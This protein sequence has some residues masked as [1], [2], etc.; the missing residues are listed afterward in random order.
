MGSGY[1]PTIINYYEEF[2]YNEELQEQTSPKTNPT[3]KHCKNNTALGPKKRYCHQSFTKS[4]YLPIY[5]N[6]SNTLL[7]FSY[8]GAQLIF[9]A[10]I[11]KAGVVRGLPKM[12]QQF[13]IQGIPVLCFLMV[14]DRSKLL[15]DTVGSL[16][17]LSML[18]TIHDLR[19]FC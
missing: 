13:S 5:L 14:R 4:S 17:L 7:L 10:G 11:N 12:T 8:K 6:L 16:C 19:D 9:S 2:T 15:L 1:L 18:N 3:R